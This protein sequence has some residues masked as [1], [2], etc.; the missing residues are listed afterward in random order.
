MEAEC[1]VVNFID[2]HS[3]AIK[4]LEDKKV[5]ATCKNCV[6]NEFYQGSDGNIKRLSKHEKVK[7]YCSKNI[8]NKTD[9]DSFVA[10]EKH[11][12]VEPDFT[13]RSW[14]V[15]DYY[16]GD[17]LKKGLKP[18]KCCG[19]CSHANNNYEGLAICRKRK[20]LQVSQ[21]DYCDWFKPW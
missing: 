15:G 18:A 3:K 16:D 1:G 9:I 14:K 6:T 21:T 4:G 8:K 5:C 12:Q 20:G 2:K 19:H 7:F 11:T 13:C 17:D 10:A